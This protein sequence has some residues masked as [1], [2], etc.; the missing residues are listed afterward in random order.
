MLT[1]RKVMQDILQ[2]LSL[3]RKT[4]KLGKLGVRRSRKAPSSIHAH[5]ATRFK[6]ASS[7]AAVN[8]ALNTG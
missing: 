3:R 4:S 7:G 5:K 6:A 1:Q 8:Y 2:H